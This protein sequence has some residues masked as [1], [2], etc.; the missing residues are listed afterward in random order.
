[1][2]NAE[3]RISCCVTLHRMVGVGLCSLRVQVAED[4]VRVGF[5]ISWGVQDDGTHG[6]L[7]HAAIG[8]GIDCI[9]SSL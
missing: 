7:P 3:L 4:G 8:Y 1:M 9:A 6:L 2:N 5:L